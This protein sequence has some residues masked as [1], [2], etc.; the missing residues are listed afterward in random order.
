MFGFTRNKP[1]KVRRTVKEMELSR[2][3][4]DILSAR[5]ELA[6]IERDI[7]KAYQRKARVYE[8]TMASIIQLDDDLADAGL[9]ERVPITTPTVGGDYTDIIGA[10]L[11]DEKLGVP[12]LAQ[13][14][15]KNFLNQKKDYIN[16]TIDG[17]VNQKLT[18]LGQKQKPRQE[19][20]Q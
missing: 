15:I 10:M 4:Q 1:S 11:T 7:G 3:D 6:D 8:Q 14:A 2:I 18:D 5:Q 9:P 12:K 20:E 13:G 17:M 16:A 19:I